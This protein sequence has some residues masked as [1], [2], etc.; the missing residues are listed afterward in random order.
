VANKTKVL[1]LC[2]HNATR[3]QMG[4][5]FLRKYAADRYEAHSA[6]L[7]A[8]DIH[9]LTLQVMAEVGLD[10]HD[11]F[12]KSVNTYLGKVHF[13][14]IITVC[15]RSEERLCPVFPGGVSNYLHWRIE[16]PSAF[17]GSDEEKLACFR[18][19][20]DTIEAMIRAWL[21]EAV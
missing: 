13:G 1:F 4:E 8:T 14:Y 19:V 11:Q 17:E 21:A 7:E 2:T 6:G 5:A 15:S 18:E 10:L 9:P 3:S 12:S 16:D 20:R